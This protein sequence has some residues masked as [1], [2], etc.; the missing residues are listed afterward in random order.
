MFEVACFVY[1]C[2][3]EQ[4]TENVDEGMVE[5]EVRFTHRKCLHHYMKRLINNSRLI[6]VK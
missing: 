2:K 5:E 4:E 3:M 1:N 6:L